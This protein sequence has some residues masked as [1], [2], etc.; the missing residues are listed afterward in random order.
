MRLHHSKERSRKVVEQK[1]RKVL[2]E[3]GSLACEACDFDFFKV[4]GQLG[5]EFA[6]CHHTVPVSELTATH[7][8]RLSELAILCANC[9]RMI[10]KS[11]PMVTVQGLRAVVESRRG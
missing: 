10:H 9:H 1:K 11:R 3:T 8:T 2:Q 4:Y 6:E 7:K 5:Y